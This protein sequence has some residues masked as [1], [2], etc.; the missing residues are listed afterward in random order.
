[1]AKDGAIDATVTVTNTGSREGDETV[2][3]YLRDVVGSISRPIKQLKGFE[4]IH[5][6]PGESR[7]VTFR[8]TPEMLKFYNYNLDFVA[9]P[10]EFIVMTGPDSERLTAASFTLLP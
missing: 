10:G 2:Q 7:D 9:E 6:K 4:K 8:I 3:L 1:M 5:L